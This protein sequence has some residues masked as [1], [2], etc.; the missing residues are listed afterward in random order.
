[1]GGASEKSILR[2]GWE[3]IRCQ[4]PIHAIAHQGNSWKMSEKSKPIHRFYSTNADT[5]RKRTLQDGSQII[6]RALSDVVVY[7]L[8]VS[9]TCA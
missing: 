4:S 3:G 6:G 8:Q 1:M 9:K 7:I 5:R 2:S